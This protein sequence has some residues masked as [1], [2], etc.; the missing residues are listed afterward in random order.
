MFHAGD[1]LPSLHEIHLDGYDFNEYP[2]IGLD[3][4]RD[5]WFE[6]RSLIA[7][8]TG[9]QSLRPTPRIQG[10]MTDPGAN[11]M[12]WKAAMDWTELRDLGLKRIDP[13]FFALM[14]GELPALESLRLG[15]L[16]SRSCQSENTTH[17]PH[18]AQSAVP[19]V[20]ARDIQTQQVL[21]RFWTD[22]AAPFNPSKFENGSATMAGDLHHLAKTSTK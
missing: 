7:Y 19:I 13:I 14:E 2:L 1:K 5:R 4:T 6:L 18:P 17:F 11:L 22:M 21:L 9:I 12:K 15:R 16:N 3:E 10:R 8:Y 20:F